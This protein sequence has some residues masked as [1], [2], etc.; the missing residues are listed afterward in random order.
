[1]NTTRNQQKSHQHEK[2]ALSLGSGSIITILYYCMI[3]QRNITLET[4]NPVQVQ[5]L[6]GVGPWQPSAQLGEYS[7]RCSDENQLRQN[8]SRAIISFTRQIELSLT[9]LKAVVCF[10]PYRLL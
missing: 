5:D 2:V 6:P 9:G 3:Q 10:Y 4:R 8:L 7:M 1:M